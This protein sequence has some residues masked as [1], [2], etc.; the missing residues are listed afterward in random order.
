LISFAESSLIKGL[1]R[2][3]GFFTSCAPFRLEGG[4][5]AASALP[6]A[7]LVCCCFGLH[8]EF[9]LAFSSEVKGWRR[10]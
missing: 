10:F 4:H 6:F 8:F 9:V 7:R 5:G 3:Q 2:P 1:R